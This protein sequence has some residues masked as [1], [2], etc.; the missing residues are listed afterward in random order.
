MSVKNRSPDG[1]DTL[2]NSEE[3]ATRIMVTCTAVEISN[4]AYI[5]LSKPVLGPATDVYFIEL[6]LLIEADLDVLVRLS[7]FNSIEHRILGMQA[8][9]SAFANDPDLLTYLPLPCV[10]KASTA[11][12]N[13]M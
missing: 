12:I 8:L 1:Y 6:P 3:A 7:K 10:S 11:C 4:D 2:C 9:I 5:E 13:W